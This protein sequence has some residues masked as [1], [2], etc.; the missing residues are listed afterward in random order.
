MS[1]P[2]P[3][4]PATTRNAF[5]DHLRV[6]LTVLVILHHTAIAYGGSGGW[7]WRQEPN[8]SNRLLLLFNATNQS[9]FMGFFFLLAGY[10]TPA[11]FDRKGAGRFLGDRFTRLGL[12][13]LGYFL[14]LSPMTIALARMGSGHAFWSGWWLMLREG[15]CEPGPLW[16][17]EALLLFAL[18]YAAWRRWVAPVQPSW[19]DFPSHRALLWAA[20]GVGVANIAVRFLMP[21]GQ[22]IAGLQLG[23]FPAYVLLFAAGC[24][25]ARGQM[26]ERV[27]LAQTRPWA[28]LSL[29][30]FVLMPVVIIF[31]GAS[32]HF[33]SGWHTNAIFYAFWD[34]L[35]GWG[36]MLTMLWGFRSHLAG[37]NVVTAFLARNAYGAYIVHP[38]VVVGLGLLLRGWAIPP[39]LKFGVVGLAACAGAW[40][41]AGLLVRVPGLKRIL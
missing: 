35:I 37:G 5:I 3:P 31:N 17:A 36:I 8:A 24:A 7:Y 13:L 28:I 9:F 12:P 38:P 39:L 2:T 25:A 34:P 30:M 41:V 6:V 32:G 26:L 19:P 27:T 21:V 15:Q 20:L 33:E 40:A 16:F 23:Y 1:A 29:V 22:N 18:V 14:I 10:Y 4:A 11:S